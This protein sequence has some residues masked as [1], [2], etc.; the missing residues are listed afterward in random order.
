[1]LLMFNEY[2]ENVGDV[3]ESSIVDDDD[4]DDDDDESAA[5]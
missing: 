5:S 3:D 1:M 2:D 4:D